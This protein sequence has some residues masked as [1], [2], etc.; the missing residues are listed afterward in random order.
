LENQPGGIARIKI[1]M[2]KRFRHIFRYVRRMLNLKIFFFS[3]ITCIVSLSHSVAQELVKIGKYK[4]PAI[5]VGE[6]TIPVINLPMVTVVDFT[7]PEI[8]KNMQAYYRL[9][10]NVLKVYPYAKLAAV[11]LNEMNEHVATLKSAKEKREYIKST[12]K[13]MKNDFEDQIKNLSVSQGDILIKLLDRETGNT[14]YEL[15]KELRGTLNAFF[16]QGLAKI[17]DHDLKDKYDPEGRDKTIESIV[18]QIESGEI[19]F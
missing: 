7:D 17:F 3:F 16:A 4:V 11:K 19:S 9:R 6:D 13:Q 8:L 5:I 10:F 12:E 15:I 14:S 1:P 2:I 18:R